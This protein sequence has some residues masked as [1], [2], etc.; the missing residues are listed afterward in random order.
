MV[1]GTRVSRHL[2]PRLFFTFQLPPI[3]T[4]GTVGT[5]PSASFAKI[6]LIFDVILHHLASRCTTVA[7]LPLCPPTRPD[8]AR[9]RARPRN[10]LFYFISAVSY[11]RVSSAFARVCA[12]ARAHTHAYPL[13]VYVKSVCERVLAEM[14]SET[15]K[16]MDS[17]CISRGDTLRYHYKILDSCKNNCGFH[18]FKL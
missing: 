2:P 9:A 3:G 17:V 13:T 14:S 16:P 6:Y 1:W 7:S 15:G 5:A 12:R 18:C 10:F 8:R 11:A 4:R